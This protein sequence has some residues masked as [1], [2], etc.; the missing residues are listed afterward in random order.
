MLAELSIHCPTPRG[1]AKIGKIQARE[2]IVPVCYS[3]SST[4]RE[5]TNSSLAT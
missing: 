3:S 5:D 1:E 2:C 4:E